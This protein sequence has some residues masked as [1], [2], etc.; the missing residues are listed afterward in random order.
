MLNLARLYS[1]SGD[2]ARDPVLNSVPEDDRTAKM[3]FALGVSYD[4]LKDNKNAIDAYSKA[5][6]MDPDNLDAETGFGAGAL[7]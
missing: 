2:S 5:F 1:D 6:D 3:E 7:E 4:Q